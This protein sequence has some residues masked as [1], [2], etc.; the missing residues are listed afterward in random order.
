MFQLVLSCTNVCFC[1]CV[2]VFNFFF[3]STW[4]MHII[5]LYTVYNFFISV[6]FYAMSQI[7]SV[8]F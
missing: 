5:V 6:I 1:N 4:G 3:I 8:W 7:S 2:F